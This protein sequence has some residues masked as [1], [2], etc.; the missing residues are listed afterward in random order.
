MRLCDYATMRR[1][2]AAAAQ[3]GVLRQPC[4]QHADAQLVVVVAIAMCAM[5]LAYTARPDPLHSWWYGGC[6]IAQAS[7]REAGGRLNDCCWCVNGPP[8]RSAQGPRLQDVAWRQSGCPFRGQW[9]AGL[10]TA[11]AGF[12]GGRGL[13]GFARIQ[14]RA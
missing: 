7:E 11:A 9:M 8:Q 14:A 4:K 13:P 3:R 6:S 5:R 2:P 1:I 10:V 12:I